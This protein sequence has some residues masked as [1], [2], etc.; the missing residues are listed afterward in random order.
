[1]TLHFVTLTLGPHCLVRGV[2][3]CKENISLNE[4]PF[5]DNGD[6]EQ[7]Q[8]AWLKHLTF[9][10]DLDLELALVLHNASLR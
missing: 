3:F 4:N 2:V 8:N 7:T 6:M 1:M 10:C 5:R 9:N